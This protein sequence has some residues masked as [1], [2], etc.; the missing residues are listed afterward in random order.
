MLDGQ[1]DAVEE[2]L[3]AAL[4]TLQESLRLSRRLAEDAR[5]RQHT[6]VADRL[7]ERAAEAARR[8]RAIQRVLENGKLDAATPEPAA[9]GECRVPSAER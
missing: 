6:R 1:T 9:H 4:N 3:W 8:A 2:A 5:R 7:D